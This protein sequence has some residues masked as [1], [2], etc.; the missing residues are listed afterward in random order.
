M[1]IDT[2]AY[3]RFTDKVCPEPNSGC[4]LWMGSVTHRGYGA[5]SYGR[6]M[7]AHVFSYLWHK[8]E[9]PEGLVV[10]HK[11]AV[12]SCVN[13]DHLEA[14]TSSVNSLEAVRMK[15]LRPRTVSA[16]AV[17]SFSDVIRLWP[18][19]EMAAS[20]IG[21]NPWTLVGWRRRNSIPADYW[22]DL[23]AAAVARGFEFLTIDFLSV[24]ASQKLKRAA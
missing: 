4:W 14:V 23:K 8:G 18:T 24:L 22:M 20:E 10:H 3:K 16:E 19:I 7:G 11:C 12:R 17:R 13:P 1:L 2:R 5:F 6:Q 21:V 9:I 15:A